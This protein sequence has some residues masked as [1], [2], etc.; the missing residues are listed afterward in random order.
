MPTK[1]FATRLTLGSEPIIGQLYN[2]FADQLLNDTSFY[3]A[4]SIP[5]VD[6]K[7]QDD[8][9]DLRRLSGESNPYVDVILD[10]GYYDE[11]LKK[12]QVDNDLKMSILCGLVKPQMGSDV[13]LSEDVANFS[14]KNASLF[15]SLTSKIISIDLQNDGN[16]D[17]SLLSS[18]PN[19]ATH[20][21]TGIEYGVQL[22]ATFTWDADVKDDDLPLAIKE[23]HAFIDLVMT[24]I[25]ASQTT[26]S[27]E[28]LEKYSDDRKFKLKEWH[29]TPQLTLPLPVNTN[30]HASFLTK[31]LQKFPKSIENVAP[32]R[33]I[34]CP[35]T[36]I[37]P[38]NSS[39]S[40]PIP[41]FIP[42]DGLTMKHI[43]AFFDD[44]MQGE[45]LLNEREEFLSRHNFCVD[46]RDREFISLFIAE[47]R[48]IWSEIK[49]KLRQQL[50][51]ARHG[52]MKYD[53]LRETA[54][55]YTKSKISLEYAQKILTAQE[56]LLEK[57]HYIQKLQDRGGRYYND[58]TNVDWLNTVQ[59]VYVEGVN[60]YVFFCNWNSSDETFLINK[61][62]FDRLL[63]SKENF[64]ILIDM[65]TV[66][67]NVNKIS[68][69]NKG[70]LVY[71]NLVQGARQIVSTEF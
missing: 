49:Q 33:M 28:S 7:N 37:F 48:K 10:N 36:E 2:A 61:Q 39:P 30:M 12:F 20:V 55:S 34:L 14:E 21:V 17:K 6:I 25:I 22:G 9:N 32:I 60:C 53:A 18:I 71:D 63:Y 8:I 47:R 41:L 11:R 38:N 52:S 50:K 51:T 4:N 45:L 54:T 62:M 19:D 56:R 27:F 23:L 15:Y 70:G 42:I 64:C 68:Y 58:S 13:F 40:W 67:E 26:Q 44:F 29:S 66:E 69:Y 35:L 24:N 31:F 46:P 3:G 16:I 59:K 1:T 65:D 57:I 5:K 43:F